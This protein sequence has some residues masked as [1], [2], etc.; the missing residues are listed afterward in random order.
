MR[1]LIPVLGFGRNGGYRVLSK[2]ADQLLILGHDVEFLC[3]EGSEEPYFETNAEVNWVSEKGITSLKSHH[4]TKDNALLIQQRLAKGLKLI[5]NQFDIIFA[6][7]S[8]TLLPILRSGLLY[9]TLYY[10][11]AYEPDYY[12][13]LPG[14]KNKILYYISLLSYNI[15]VFTIVNADIYSKY[16]NI[17]SRDVLYPGIDFQKFYPKNSLPENDK[18]ILG[19]IGRTEAFKGTKQIIEAFTIL[20]QQYSNLQLQ[21]AYGDIE[22]ERIEGIKCIYPKNDTELGSYYRDLDFYIS[23]QF[24]QPGAF[25]YPTAEAMASG[26]AV[27]TTLSY[28]ANNENSWLIEPQNSKD[29]VKK[30][31]GAHANKIARLE[32]TQQALLD[33]R[34]FDWKTT[35]IKLEGLLKQLILK[36]TS[37]PKMITSQHLKNSKE[38]PLYNEYKPKEFPL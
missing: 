31:E 38:P 28:P 20:K 24:S 30:F 27:I 9:K 29:I 5:G 25:H 34:Q 12:K 22:L 8:L 17:R 7:H 26:V 6:N 37:D 23:A 2:L 16:K 19:T 14:F 3:S 32:K 13:H 11:Q 10:I 18:I 35:G 4:F 33:I 36:Y 21:V 1:I 15:K